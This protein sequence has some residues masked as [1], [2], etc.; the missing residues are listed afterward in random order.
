LPGVCLGFDGEEHY[1]ISQAAIQLAYS[2]ALGL[3]RPPVE[4]STEEGLTCSPDGA[5]EAVDFCSWEV[6]S[7]IGTT[8]LERETSMLEV[9]ASDSPSHFSFGDFAVH[10]DSVDDP[11]KLIRPDPRRDIQGSP[12]DE[13]DLDLDFLIRVRTRLTGK[14]QSLHSNTSHFQDHLVF[15]Y[16]EWQREAMREA[17]LAGRDANA[18]LRAQKVREALNEIGKKSAA[19]AGV[20]GAAASV[21]KA[22]DDVQAVRDTIVS[23]DDLK[24]LE[25]KVETELKKIPPS[26]VKAPPPPPAAPQVEGD[27]PGASREPQNKRAEATASS[28]VAGG[29][30]EA[31]GAPL[32]Q[33]Q[34]RPEQETAPAPNQTKK[35]GRKESPGALSPT[36]R[37]AKIAYEA[38]SDAK[39]SLKKLKNRLGDGAA[40]PDAIAALDKLASSLVDSTKEIDRLVQE[41]RNERLRLLESVGAL[42]GLP[43]GIAIGTVEQR[44]ADRL[45]AILRQDK[46]AGTSPNRSLY[47]ALLKNALAAHYL[48]DFFAPG[49]IAAMREGQPDYAANTIHDRYNSR[50]ACF[51]LKNTEPFKGLRATLEKDDELSRSVARFLGLTIEELRNA[52]DDLLDDSA[53]A[54]NNRCRGAADIFLR[55]DGDLLHPSATGVTNE[56][57][58]TRDCSVESRL[59]RV[60]VTFAVA[61]SVVDTFRAYASGYANALECASDA[62]SLLPYR[63]ERM[64]LVE[65]KLLRR[66][67]VKMPIASLQIGGYR[68]E[69]ETVNPKYGFMGLLEVEAETFLE[70]S[71][72]GGRGRVGF[73]WLPAQGPAGLEVENFY[74]PKLY[75]IAL[76]VGG[77]YR[78]DERLP[79]PDATARLY[80]VWPKIDMHVSAGARVGWYESE[81]QHTVRVSPELRFGKSFGFLGA[82]LGLSEDYR[83][84]VGGSLKHSLAIQSG[85]QL[86]LPWWRVKRTVGNWLH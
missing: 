46:E 4:C 35:E 41:A 75:T 10:V 34:V 37:A 26:D 38:L 68:R 44:L 6:L 85:V 69:P 76:G 22:I 7:T 82:F 29:G 40:Q 65:P 20:E 64:E 24:D 19:L 49:H 66:Q 67:L 8:I 79:G 77:G 43:P 16:S 50:G 27:G 78:W 72:E 42:L 11:L 17:F 80:L 52:T 81:G 51:S 25:K 45:K 62:G 83:E 30:A 21:R 47:Y 57:C 12:R 60:L 15:S 48:E 54:G 58:S 53:T 18:Q 74:V 28:H 71:Q 31:V 5:E 63:W 2:H 33:R 61:Q 3:A 14:L 9:L 55:G 23:R 1:R 39:A 70:G 13:G 32:P 86:A 56:E 73:E 84:E 59:E 36:E